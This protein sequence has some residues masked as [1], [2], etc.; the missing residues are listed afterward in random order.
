MKLI[1]IFFT[2]IAYLWT[3]AASAFGIAV[4]AFLPFG[5]IGYIINFAR[6][7]GLESSYTDAQ[8]AITAIGVAFPP[9]GAIIGLFG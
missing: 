4:F 2:S 5:I 1:S 9:L 3:L 6:W 7:M 8:S